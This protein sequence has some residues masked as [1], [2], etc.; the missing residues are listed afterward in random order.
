MVVGWIILQL[1]V[2][3]SGETF[4]KWALGGDKVAITLLLLTTV[5]SGGAI[6]FQAEDNLKPCI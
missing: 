1:G 3:F 4:W 5:A 2:L 6:G